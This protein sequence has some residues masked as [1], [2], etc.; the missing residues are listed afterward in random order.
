MHKSLLDQRVEESYQQILTHLEKGIIPF[1]LG[2]G[3]DPVEGGYLTC[4]DENG[5]PTDDTDKYIVTQTRMIWGMSALY[6]TYPDNEIF[7][8]AA[9]QG[10]SFFLDNFWDDKYGGWYWKTDRTG[11]VIDTG[12]VTYGQCFAIYALSEYT[13][14]TSDPIGLEYAEKTFDLMQK[15]CAD[16]YRGGYF[17]NLEE[18]WTVSQPGFHAGDRKSLDIHMHIM[19]AFTNLS[20]CS[21]KELHNRKLKEIINVIL[22]KMIHKKSGCAMNQFDL[23]F[24]P[25]PA[26]DIRRT[27]NAERAIGE[28]ISE[29]IDTTSYGHNLEL[30]W[31][32]TRA[33]DILG[34][35]NNYKGIL[36]NLADHA[37]K[38]GV[39]PVYGGLYRDGPHEGEPY[40][41][42]KEWWQNS[43]ALVGF[44]D[45]YEQLGDS[46]YLKAF[47][48]IWTFSMEHIINHDVGEWKQL[49]RRDGHTIVGDI[50]NPWKAIYHSGRSMLECKKRLQRIL[51]QPSS[52][53]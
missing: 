21:G 41:Y 26:I 51:N 53:L 33:V 12:K 17:E 34:E 10:V 16:T 52:P 45:A 18:D 39:D 50:G 19:E 44:L 25:I 37:L 24:N 22:S 48:N 3:I 11:K 31:L 27:W 1:W 28:I 36:R 20:E 14:A 9:K 43:E 46:E 6:R 23:D 42:D 8:Q 49:L 30:G 13:L 35:E 2:N 40:V 5:L 32:L 15:F 47:I 29:P 7:L 4:F 38:N